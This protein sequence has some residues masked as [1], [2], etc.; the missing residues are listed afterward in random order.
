MAVH[1][2]DITG[3]H[4]SS[5]FEYPYIPTHRATLYCRICTVH[6]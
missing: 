2:E 6:L 3:I 5:L 4:V 1:K